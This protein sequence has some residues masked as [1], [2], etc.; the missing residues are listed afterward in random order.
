MG[1][2]ASTATV[3]WLPT[4]YAWSKR[5]Y[6]FAFAAAIAHQQSCGAAPRDGCFAAEA[7]TRRSALRLLVSDKGS[8]ARVGAHATARAIPIVPRGARRR[9]GM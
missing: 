6:G 9:R 2:E 3:S 4:T 8:R 1:P 7:A 5:F